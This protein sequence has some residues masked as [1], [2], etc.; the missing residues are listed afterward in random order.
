MVIGAF[1]DLAVNKVSIHS[2]GRHA[3]VK[4]E[5]QSSTFTCYGFHGI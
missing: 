4:N 5:S 1:L 2:T 3:A